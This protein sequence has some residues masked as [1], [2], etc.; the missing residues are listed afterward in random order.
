VPQPS[1]IT[2]KRDTQLLAVRTTLGHFHR[3]ATL[4]LQQHGQQSALG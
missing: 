2:R 1:E 3:F 4:V